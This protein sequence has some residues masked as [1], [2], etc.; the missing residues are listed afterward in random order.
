MNKLY[1]FGETPS[2]KNS[3][4]VLPNGRNIPGKRYQQW[5]KDAMQQLV[6]QIKDHKDLPITDEVSIRLD[7]VHGDMRRRDSDNGTSSVLDL[8]TDAG[9]IADDKWQIV[10]KLQ[11]SNFYRKN[12]P[13]CIVE[14]EKYHE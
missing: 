10:R 9:I 5:H 11:I 2:K 12:D 8:L 7:F 4:I 6:E 14:I 1:I 3:R 13:M